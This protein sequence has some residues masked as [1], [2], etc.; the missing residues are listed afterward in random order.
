MTKKASLLSIFL[1][2]SFVPNNQTKEHIDD[3]I[4]IFSYVSDTAGSFLFICFRNYF[5]LFAKK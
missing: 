1:K 4:S 5:I 3:V 2:N